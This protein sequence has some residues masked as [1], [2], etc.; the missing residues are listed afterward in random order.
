MPLFPSQLHAP[1]SSSSKGVRTAAYII[2]IA[3]I[4]F[5]QFASGPRTL[6]R[7]FSTIC[8]DRQYRDALCTT[9][10]GAPEFPSCID[11]IGPC[12]YLDGIQI[13]ATQQSC[14]QPTDHALDR[15]NN[16]KR[17]YS[18][19][20]TSFLASIGESRCP[21]AIAPADRQS[22]KIIAIS[23]ARAQRASSRMAMSKTVPNHK[24]RNDHGHRSLIES[25]SED[26]Q[27]IPF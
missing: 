3:Q 15:P 19:A 14:P 20:W 25:S 1:P 6:A 7:A 12:P 10:S 26:W 21:L 13:Q 23:T 8:L 16:T 27:R 9:S 2:I 22:R 18:P 17:S 24:K 5:Y 4:L 11:E